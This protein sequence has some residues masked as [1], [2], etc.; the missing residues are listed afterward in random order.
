MSSLICILLYKF[1]RVG[2]VISVTVLCKSEHFFS[3]SSGVQS[4][5][6]LLFSLAIVS[7]L[8]LKSI[9][10]QVMAVSGENWLVFDH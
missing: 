1:S 2:E 9:W 3:S 6:G 4:G 7:I 10:S 8:Q 5:V